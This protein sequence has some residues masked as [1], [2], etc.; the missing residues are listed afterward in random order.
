MLWCVREKEGEMIFLLWRVEID[1]I[2]ITL[3]KEGL[4]FKVKALESVRHRFDSAL[5]MGS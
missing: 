5:V 1:Y 4:I 2:W 3:V